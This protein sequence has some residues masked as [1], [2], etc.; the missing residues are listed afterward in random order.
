MIERRDPRV[1]QLA[2]EFVAYCGD[3]ERL[4]RGRRAPLNAQLQRAAASIL[5]NIGEG[6]DELSKTDQ[7]RFFR[8]AIRSAGESQRLLQGLTIVGA[9]DPTQTAPGYALLKDIKFD[10]L[11]LIQ[12]STTHP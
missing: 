2:L 6:F 9:L 5:S 10:L 1:V 11:R 3:I 7:R 4:L 12:W 8:Y